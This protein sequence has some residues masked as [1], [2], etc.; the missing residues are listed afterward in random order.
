MS[1]LA[2]AN[3]PSSAA[4]TTLRSALL[5]WLVSFAG[6]PLG[7]LAAMVLVGPVDTLGSALAGGVVTGAVLGTVQAWALGG[8]GIRP[9][10]WVAATSLGLTTGLALGAWLVDFG[11]GLGDLVVQGAVC[12]GVIGVAQAVLLVPRVGARGLL[13]PIALAGIWG[14]GWTV[15]TSIGIQVEDQYTVFGSSGALVVTVLGAILPLA[16]HRNGPGSRS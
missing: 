3:P 4:R 1:H 14:L 12:G 10:A 2:T 13:W 5:R 16:L 6:F 11:T 15:S 9:A 8:V 7:G